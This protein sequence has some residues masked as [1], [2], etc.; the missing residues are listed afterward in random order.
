MNLVPVTEP[1]KI[2]LKSSTST[3]LVT[4]GESVQFYL[5]A[6]MRA[7]TDA[8]DEW[9]KVIVFSPYWW[10]KK[11]SDEKECNLKVKK[12]TVG[13]FTF[14]ILENYKGIKAFEKL[15]VYELESPAKKA[16]S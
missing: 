5:E 16:R 1:G 8:T 3:A 2:A 10:A 12:Q 13:E 14:P 11:S 4:A 7:T 9:K 6:P 15:V